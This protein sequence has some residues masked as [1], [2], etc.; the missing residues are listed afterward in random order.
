M[1]VG[2]PGERR[3]GGAVLWCAPGEGL[4]ALDSPM[5]RGSFVQGQVKDWPRPAFWQDAQFASEALVLR[6]EP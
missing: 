1:E 3:G 6:S 5:G 4:W 2:C